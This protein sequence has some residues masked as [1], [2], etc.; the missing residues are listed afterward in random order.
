MPTKHLKRF[1]KLTKTH[2]NLVIGVLEL[3]ENG[4]YDISYHN[5][6]QCSNGIYWQLYV[7]QT[8]KSPRVKGGNIFRMKL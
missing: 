2:T 5:L 6:K 7:P 1:L 3:I 4:I 8:Y